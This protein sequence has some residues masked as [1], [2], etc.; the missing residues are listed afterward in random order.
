MNAGVIFNIQRFSLH[1]GPGIRTTVFLKGC[2][3]NCHW[4]QN[5]E[6]LDP[7]PELLFN[8]EKCI[9]CGRCVP[10][11]PENAIT[12]E[13]GAVTIEASSCTHCGQCAEACPASALEMIG[14]RMTAEEVVE[15]IDADHTFYEVSGGGVTLSGGE[16]LAQPD[17]SAEILRLCKERGYH[18]TVDTTGHADWAD[19]ETLLPYTDLFLFDIKHCDDAAHTQ[20]TDASLFP[21]L[22]NLKRLSRCGVEVVARFPVVPGVNND[23]KSVARIGTIAKENGIDTIHILS[24]HNHAQG[25]VNRLVR[26]RDIQPFPLLEKNETERIAEILEKQKLNVIIGG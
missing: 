17:F 9:R 15:E 7:K 21:I 26:Q 25:K 23:E 3:L 19:F 11:C 2:P 12:M 18:T 13:K 5:P 14:R 4:C 10:A 8:A 16:A 20:Y 6:G 24:Y 22:G 1:D